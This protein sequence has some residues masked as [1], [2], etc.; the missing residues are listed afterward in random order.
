MI[1]DYLEECVTLLQS[2]FWMHC[3]LLNSKSVSDAIKELQLPNLLLTIVLAGRIGVLRS[4]L[5]DIL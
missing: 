1:R 4:K 5:R 3:N 2:E